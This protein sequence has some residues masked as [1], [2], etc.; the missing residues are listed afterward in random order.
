MV[1]VDTTPP[2]PVGTPSREP[3]PITAPHAPDTAQLL[4]PKGSVLRAHLSSLLTPALTVPIAGDVG[5]ATQLTHLQDR[6]HERTGAQIVF[7]RKELSEGTYYDSL[8]PLSLE[9]QVRAAEIAVREAQK[10]PSGLLAKL[11]LKTFG[12]FE[13]C[14]AQTNDGFHE[15]DPRYGGYRWYGLYNFSH[16][17][18]GA[19]YS[20]A[21][22]PLTIHHEIFHAIDAHHRG[23]RGMQHYESDNI[24]FSQAVQGGKNYPALSLAPVTLDALKKV[25]R[26]FVLQDAVSAYTT[27]SPDEDQAEAARHFMM[28]IADSLIQAAERPQLPGS[29][30]ILHILD[31]YRTCVD[32]GPDAS[33]FA[34]VALGL[35]QSTALT[36]KT[37]KPSSG[38]NLSA[39]LDSSESLDP[40]AAMKSLLAT[41]TNE[42]RAFIIRGAAVDDYQPNLTLQ[43][44]IR[45]FATQAKHLVGIQEK[46]K[47]RYRAEDDVREILGLLEAYEGFINLNYKVSRE[48]RKIFQETR[49]EVLN[50]LP[51]RPRRELLPRLFNSHY[52]GKVDRAINSAFADKPNVKEIASTIR[53]VQPAVVLVN[54]ASGF[55]INADGMILT[56]AHVTKELG[57][58]MKVQFP[59][60][61]IFEG[62]CTH[63]DEEIDLALV[64]LKGV[65]KRLPFVRFSNEEAPVGSDIVLIGQ[66]DTYDS[67][68]VSTGKILNYHSH[69]H[70]AVDGYP[71]GGIEHNGWTFW[72]NSG[73]PIF[74]LKGLVVGTHNT[75]DDKRNMRCGVRY[76]PTIE[77]LKRAKATFELDR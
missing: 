55:N 63:I 13:A 22:L 38:T 52:L 26:G 2:Q 4:V 64:R 67:W 36:P 47:G 17:A 33:W 58:S 51:E 6:F 76:Q 35:T 50:I 11:G 10:Y 15:Y 57:S 59:N 42:K 32:S 12:I 77:F 62:L 9:R 29:Q 66:P 5:L 43:G 60:G 48:T 40:N 49:Q 53:S 8:P 61:D 21:Q 7:S 28:N 41:I 65:H 3:I 71:L 1:C 19:Y 72:G 45:S 34:A 74:N 73:S 31:Q 14:I 18:V 69:P 23:E 75:Y 37:P 39:A 46:T 70:T 30:R 24:R 56:N 27:K 54:R 68:H 16:G 20:D 44:D 25:S